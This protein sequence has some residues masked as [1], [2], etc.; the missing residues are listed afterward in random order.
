[1]GRTGS[2]PERCDR[3]SFGLMTAS[4]RRAILFDLFGTLVYFD[5][6]RV[7]VLELPSGPVR[8]TIPAYTALLAEIAPDVTPGRFYEA[9]M[10]VSGEMVEAQRRSHRE[11]PSRERFARTL[12]RLGVRGA[13]LD[14][15]AERLACAHME[16]LA[17]ATTVP[18]A[19]PLLLERL[20]GQA[21][22]GCISNFDH[23]ASASR[24]LERAGLTPFLEVVVIS[25]AFGWR[26]PAPAIFHEALR[27]LDVLPSA[28]LF[29]GD[30]L[31][32]DIRGAMAAGLRAV[33][34]NRSGTVAPPDVCPT[35]IINDVLEIET[36]LASIAQ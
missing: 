19:H 3:S 36:V 21:A 13:M 22:L 32:E 27:L 35:A 33:W 7:P 9:L 17:M 5:R 1:M 2:D 31:D 34:I 20:S 11:L 4:K 18:E 6:S 16:Q 23:T 14:A 25:E 24:I 12:R 10:A 15:H 26:K 28:A 29:V 30:T 8:S